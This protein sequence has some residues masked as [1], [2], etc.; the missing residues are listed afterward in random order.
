MIRSTSSTRNR[1]A[2]PIRTGCKNPEAANRRIV[3]AARRAGRRGSRPETCPAH[4]EV[5]GRIARS[6]FGAW[7]TRVDLNSVPQWLPSQLWACAPSKGCR[8]RGRP[9]TRFHRTRNQD[10]G[11]SE[12]RQ[13]RAPPTPT[14]CGFD[15]QP[16]LAQ[17]VN[18]YCSC[19]GSYR[20]P[21]VL[22]LSKPGRNCARFWD[23]SAG[24][25]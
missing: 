5:S 8:H 19:G 16:D 15:H 20:A 7:S 2:R 21:T 11:A 10:W 13:G 14:A 17:M 23:G 24:E 22:A 6:S 18:G 12:P 3:L 1:T 4:A 25:Y 9:W